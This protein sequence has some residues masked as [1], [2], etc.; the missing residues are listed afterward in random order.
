MIFQKKHKICCWISD[1]E[2]N[3][4]AAFWELEF[5]GRKTALMVAN[6]LA[7]GEDWDYGS[8]ERRHADD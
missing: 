3:L 7:H 8:I 1:E 2:M 4:L 5:K 6:Q